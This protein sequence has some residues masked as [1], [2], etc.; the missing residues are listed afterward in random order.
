[1]LAPASKMVTGNPDGQATSVTHDGR[2]LLTGL[3]QPFHAGRYHSLIV[4]EDTLPRDLNVT[5]RG[6]GGVPMG[7]RHATH[8]TVGAQFHP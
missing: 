3:P 1:M 2:G 5:A 7:V 6:P 4:A 8:P